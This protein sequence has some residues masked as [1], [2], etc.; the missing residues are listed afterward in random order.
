VGVRQTLRD[1]VARLAN[2][3]ET[4]FEFGREILLD[5]RVGLAAE[6]ALAAL[7]VVGNRRRRKLDLLALLPPLEKLSREAQHLLVAVAL[8]G[9]LND[10]SSAGSSGLPPSSSVCQAARRTFTSSSSSIRYSAAHTSSMRLRTWQGQSKE[11][12]CR[13]SAGSLLSDS[14]NN[15]LISSRPMRS[16]PSRKAARWCLFKPFLRPLTPFALLTISTPLSKVPSPLPYQQNP[17]SVK[18]FD[19]I[20]S[21]LYS[22]LLLIPKDSQ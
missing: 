13:R 11:A 9:A 3:G 2:Q 17:H 21:T 12:A 15:A 16:S 8:E 1:L 20:S 7:G 4:P 14:C 19:T 6:V 10:S 22:R 5:P 18:P